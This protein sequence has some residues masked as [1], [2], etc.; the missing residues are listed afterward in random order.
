MTEVECNLKLD[1]YLN[2]GF[3][4]ILKGAMRAT[5]Q[6]S[7]ESIFLV[8]YSFF[9]MKA[10]SIRNTYGQMGKHIP[11]FLI[12]GITEEE[13]REKKSELSKEEWGRIFKEANDLGIGLISLTG[14]DPF[15]RKDV[16]YEAALHKSIVF[17]ILTKA[18][19]LQEYIGL[20][21]ENRN[22]VPVLYAKED[23]D[24]RNEVLQEE[25]LIEKMKM[26]QEKSLFY[27][28][29]ITVKK[30]NIQEVTKEEYVDRL[31]QLGCCFVLYLEYIPYKKQMKNLSPNQEDRKLFKERLEQLKQK[32]KDML[33]LALPGEEKEYGGCLA[34]GRGFFYLTSEGNAAPC[35][36]S[37]YG[38]M[39]IKDHSV[40]EILDCPLFER[41]RNAAHLMENH[42]GN[43]VLLQ[44][45]FEKE[46]LL[47]ETGTM[48]SEL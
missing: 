41:L 26:L 4:K 36:F 6:N 14:D 31:R 39:N 44:E 40:L 32:K 19:T 15:L 46:H 34:A 43:C 35:A 22:L 33:Y 9:A 17:P 25:K 10:S 47:Q 16:I 38:D 20:L 13:S 11:P 30:D 48:E 7:K 1:E 18:Q 23:E 8:R 27:G 5:L 2:R 12:A 37:P 42:E 45:D 3:D 24:D 28:V 29:A 21:D